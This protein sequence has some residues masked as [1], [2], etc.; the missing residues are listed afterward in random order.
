MPRHPRLHASG[1]LFHIIVRGNN[2]QDIY[3]DSTDYEEF[4]DA[5]EGTRTRYPFYLYAYVLMPNH[6]HLLVEVRE[7]PTARLM[8]ALLTRYARGFNRRHQRSGHVFQGRYKA[9]V[10]EQDSYLL[11]LV[12]Y[13]H[14]NPVRAR[15]VRRPGQ[16][17]W[18][19][20]REYLG[21]TRRGLIDPGPVQEVLGP[22][23]QYDAFVRAG[24]K[25]SYRPEWH[26][27]EQVPVL[28][29]ERFM[30]RLLRKKPLSSSGPRPTLMTLWRQ[31]A[32]TLGLS[33]D[34]LRF[35]GR[36]AVVVAAR[37]SFIRQAVGEAGYRGA[38]VAAF[39]GCHPSN[40][41]RALR[42]G[43]LAG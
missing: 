15:L 3:L 33:P 42:K 7:T 4:L 1:L 12:R 18:S 16:W 34:V 37:D 5:I 36:R 9:I 32:T 19:G 14:L 27:G 13:I 26:P 24:L 31:T 11:E 10:C 23:D 22:P 8:Q 6:F 29:P 21:K 30:K 17:P 28:G 2:K 35:G 25:D 40:I 20:H 43:G 41:T 39:L 38:A